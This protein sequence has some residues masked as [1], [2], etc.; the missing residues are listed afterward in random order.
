MQF[1]VL[2]TI[3]G[4]F[5]YLIKNFTQY[6]IPAFFEVLLFFLNLILALVYG[7]F[8]AIWGFIKFVLG[9][10][11]KIAGTKTVSDVVEGSY[12]DEHGVRRK[13]KII[14]NKTF[15]VDKHGRV[16]DEPTRFFK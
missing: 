8:K 2:A 1:I 5:F 7:L 13:R 15:N 9:I 6:V 11:P 4:A 16:I 3:V 12:I 10:K 14:T